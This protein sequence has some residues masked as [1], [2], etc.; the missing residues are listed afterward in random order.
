MIPW[1]VK[2]IAVVLLALTSPAAALDLRRAT[3]ELGSSPSPIQKKAATMIAEEVEKRTQLRLAAQ[4]SR[5]RRA[6]HQNQQGF[7]TG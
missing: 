3:V 2:K 7:G 5:L 4:F 6:R 1:P